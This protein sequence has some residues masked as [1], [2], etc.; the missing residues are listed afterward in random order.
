MNLGG[1]STGENIA[2]P[3]A[4]ATASVSPSLETATTTVPGSSPEAEGEAGWT[5]L[6]ADK[7]VDNTNRSIDVSNTNTPIPNPIV[8]DTSP[9][10]NIRE[11]PIRIETSTSATAPPTAST[12][13]TSTTDS[14]TTTPT[15]QT[16]QA[17]ATAR[18]IYPAL[19]VFHPQFQQVMDGIT[20]VV[21]NVTRR[22]SPTAG[23]IPNPPT[24]TPV[25]TPPTSLPQ[26]A[27]PPQELNEQMM[28]TLN[29]LLSMGFSNHDGWLARLVASKNGNLDEILNSLFPAGNSSN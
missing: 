29:Q 5:L 19:P 17:P 20:N 25:P 16:G 28:M 26:Q 9:A 1:E 3:N 15:G 12:A 27:T 6:E 2:A 7:S 18:P 8:L 11:I 24:S 21:G 14:A 22:Y 10:D 23:W 13:S 4:S